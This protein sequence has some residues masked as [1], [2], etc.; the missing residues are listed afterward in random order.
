MIRTIFP[1]RSPR[2]G[3][4]SRSRAARRRQP[5]RLEPLE[6]R[7]LLT[8]VAFADSLGA[9]GQNV[10]VEGGKTGGSGNTFLTGS[11][12]GS[13]AFGSI[14][15]Q[16]TGQ[17]D[18]FVAKLDPKGNVL[19]AEDLGS[20]ASTDDDFGRGV[21]LDSAGNVYVTGVFTGTAKFGPTPP[22]SVGGQ[23]IFVAK[24]DTNGNIL[25]AKGFGGQTSDQGQ[26]ITVDPSGNVYTTGNFSGI[27]DFGGTV[28]TS[29]G[30]TNV[31][32]TKQDANGN[33][34]WV[35]SFGNGTGNAPDQ[36]DSG[37]GIAVDNAGN[38]YA[39]GIFSDTIT[40]GSTT[41][42]SHGETDG[43]FAKLDPTGAPQWALQIGGTDAANDHDEGLGIV[44]D[45]SGNSYATGDFKGTATIGSS[46]LVSAGQNDAFV[47][48]ISPAGTVAWALD[49]GGTGSDAGFGVTLDRTG[50]NV[51]ATG[52]FQNTVAVGTTVLTSNGGYDVYLATINPAGAVQAAQSFGST[53]D[54]QAFGVSFG[55][56][57]ATVFGTYGGAVNIGN[58]GLKANSGNGFVAS[59]YEKTPAIPVTD[60]PSNFDKVGY[61]QVSVFR[62]STAQWIVRGPSGNTT[63][64]FG[65]TNN[66]DIP[67]S[68][69]YD[70]IGQTELAVFR[71]ST[72]QWIV[73][74]PSGSH[75]VATFGATNL[76]DIPVPGDY[77]GLGYTEPAVFR[78]ST[79]QWFVDGPN[80]PYLFATFGA[81]NLFD[82]PVPGDYDG[83][84]HTEAAVFRPSTG[85][86]FVL[87]PSGSHQ[88]A[89]FGA[90]NLFDIP[91]PGDY[92]GTGVTQQA[93][94]RPSTGQWFV[95]GPNGSQLLTTFG[96][97]NLFDYPT[98]A[99]IGAIVKLEEGGSFHTESIGGPSGGNGSSAG[100]GVSLGAF[101]LSAGNGGSGTTAVS[102]APTSPVSA[103]LAT[104]PATGLV[105]TVVVNQALS[106]TGAKKD[107]WSLALD[108][109]GGLGPAD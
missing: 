44:T 72:A 92:F 82:I 22:V 109:L 5:V 94:F 20:T 99:F 10:T 83:V 104:G 88:L 18:A 77:N 61:S 98:E 85:Q 78:P 60:P 68:G 37:F 102:R 56:S 33:L 74:G 95:L 42:T 63:T 15:L 69:D 23:D 80:G 17:T 51:Y 73:K 53:N 1:A 30:L 38:V 106:P 62:P 9:S 49:V 93:V 29:L 28:L 31:F 12:S 16:S 66:F 39:T 97:T 34:L 55:G 52:I 76:F 54:D 96:A 100:G 2:R 43:F 71:P 26:A 4:G 84:G 14:T 19:W 7:A 89:S 25:W 3:D 64:T 32:V 86:W 35:K 59:F 90:T 6:G 45:A 13:A 47:T 103:T 87:G 105:P 70:K 79:G 48:R 46:V 24:L 75:V 57:S 67:V 101:N 58:F 50:G 21:A 27:A 40:F 81:T 91:A 11:F 65:A 107:L 36:G 8:A 108:D 41:L